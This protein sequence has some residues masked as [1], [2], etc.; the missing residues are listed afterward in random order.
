MAR[1]DSAEKRE[2]GCWICKWKCHNSSSRSRGRGS[3]GR[4]TNEVKLSNVNCSWRK[5]KQDVWGFPVHC[6]RG[7]C[8]TLSAAAP[9]VA[10]CTWGIKFK[11]KCR[12]LY[13][14]TATMKRN[15]TE[16]DVTRRLLCLSGYVC[17]CVFVCGSNYLPHSVTDSLCLAHTLETT[18]IW[19]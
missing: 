9:A 10:G 11:W 14:K 19:L 2:K 6:I 5:W 15:F 18:L 4:R 1:E 3:D 8:V 13:E 7:V 12:V 16:S 17:V